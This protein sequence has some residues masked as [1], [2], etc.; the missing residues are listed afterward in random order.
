MPSSYQALVWLGTAWIGL[1]WLGLAW[2][3]LAWPGWVGRM[4]W[5][6]I[7]LN[8][9]YQVSLQSLGGGWG[10]EKIKTKAKPSLG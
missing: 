9:H 3:S 1:V 10:V 8:L 6:G 2:H 7:H 4:V 5:F